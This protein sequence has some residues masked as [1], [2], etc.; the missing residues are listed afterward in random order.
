MNIFVYTRHNL[1]GLIFS[2]LGYGLQTFFYGRKLRGCEYAS[3]M[4]RSRPSNWSSNIFSIEDSIIVY[5]LVVWDHE[6]IRA[7]VNRP[8]QSL[9]EA[10]AVACIW[11]PLIVPVPSSSMIRQSV[12][13]VNPQ[14]SARRTEDLCFRRTLFL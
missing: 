3:V 10:R 1:E 14:W 4:V 9:P 2:F 6:G 5:W 13:P 11:A 7:P 8:P 12:E